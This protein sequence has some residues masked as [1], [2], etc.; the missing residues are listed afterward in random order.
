[1]S[2]PEYYAEIERSERIQVHTLD[3]YGN[4]H[5][6]EVDGLLARIIQHEVDHLNGKLFIDHMPK[7]KRDVFKRKWVKERQEAKKS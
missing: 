3:R 7:V 2:I 4:P 5:D 1:M 6:F